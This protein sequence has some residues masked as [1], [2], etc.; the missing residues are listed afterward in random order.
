MYGQTS[1]HTSVW[2]WVTRSQNDKQC[3]PFNEVRTNVPHFRVFPSN[4]VKIKFQLSQGEL[5]S[6]N[7]SFASRAR[8]ETYLYYF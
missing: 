3:S 6:W 5:Y 8:C 7:N 4:T 2:L 1:L